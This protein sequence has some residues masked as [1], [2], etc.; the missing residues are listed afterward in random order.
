MDNGPRPDYDRPPII[1]TVLGAQFE[2]LPGFKNAHLGAFW[3]TLDSDEWP[4]VSDAPPLQPQFERFAES[5][6]WAKGLQIQLTQDPTSRVQIKNKAGDRMVQ[7]QN[8]RIHFN[9]LG[10]EGGEYPHYEKVRQGF[11]W[12]LKRFVE[13]LAEEKLGDFRPNQWEVTYI[14]HIPKGTVWDTPNDWCFFR[15]LA[16]VP[17]IENLV[18]GEGFTGEWH[19]VIPEQR[20]RL[21]VQWR[22][23]L[24]PDP[25]QES[26]EVIRLTMTA[27]GPVEQTEKEAESILDGLDLGR[28]VIVRSFER[29]MTDE[30]NR[31]WGLK[32]ATDTS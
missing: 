22:H 29:F 16:S 20:G 2:R 1:E 9:W 10:D 31:H 30:A 4:T 23:A 28:E 8:G 15:P 3:R 17:T 25:E 7:V 19:F 24:R 26:E 6:R 27:R 32:Y 11:A 13:F 14:N 18:Q 21:H 12:V 5:A